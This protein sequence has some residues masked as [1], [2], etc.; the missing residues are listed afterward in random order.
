MT[1][2]EDAFARLV[3]DLESKKTL[4]HVKDYLGVS[5]EQMNEHVKHHG[6]ITHPNLG[7]QRGFFLDEGR[8]V[9]FR[10]DVYGRCVVRPYIC[11]KLLEWSGWNGRVMNAL[12]NVVLDGTTLRVPDVAYVPRNRLHTN[13]PTEWT[14]D[15]EPFAPTFVVEID[16][17]AGPN[18]NLR[19][20]DHKMRREYFPHG[21]ELGWLIDPE[22]KLMY[23]YKRDDEGVRC[24]DS[25]TWRDLHGGTV[26][27]G[28]TLAS[29]G[30][31]KV[32]E[33]ASG[34]HHQKKNW[35]VLIKAADN[36][37]AL[38]GHL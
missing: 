26:L 3:R 10:L 11:H 2:G 14:R 5:L 24:V 7:E 38:L 28:F 16:T 36:S 17:L 30:L 32:L 20:L 8:F 22:N 31:D 27:P 6:P 35:S 25:N 21:V 19:A 1:D 18:S 4:C 29:G 23:E 12:G 15:G 13:Q 34:R 37:S 9:P 33:E